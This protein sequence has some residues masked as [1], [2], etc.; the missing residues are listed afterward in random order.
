M[1]FSPEK[2]RGFYPK[3]WQLDI[4]VFRKS[5]MG[6]LMVR[7]PFSEPPQISGDWIFKPFAVVS[8]TWMHPASSPI[9]GEIQ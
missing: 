9:R 8:V 7:P 5:G 4:R 2:V 6:I 3:I 1:G